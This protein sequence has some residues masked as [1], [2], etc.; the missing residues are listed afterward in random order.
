MWYKPQFY[1]R[2]LQIYFYY[3]YYYYYITATT[4]LYTVLCYYYYIR[5]YITTT[6]AINSIRSSPDYEA[7]CEKQH[8]SRRTI[9]CRI[10]AVMSAVSMDP[11]QH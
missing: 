5:L 1:P 8:V 6:T 4:E 11:L 9:H 2:L 3:Y 7:P 10:A